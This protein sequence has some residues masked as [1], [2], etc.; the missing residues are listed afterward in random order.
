MNCASLYMCF[1]DSACRLKSSY[2]ISVVFAAQREHKQPFEPSARQPVR[3][4]MHLRQLQSP[5]YC[6]QPALHFKGLPARAA[7]AAS[8]GSAESPARCECRRGDTANMRP[9]TI[10]RSC[11]PEAGW[12]KRSHPRRRRWAE[13]TP[14][15]EVPSN[16]Y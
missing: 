14:A 2:G 9:R 12:T 7:L 16:R 6:T 4:F 3:P 8:P 15:P 13:G 5:Q 10:P 1:R 11:V